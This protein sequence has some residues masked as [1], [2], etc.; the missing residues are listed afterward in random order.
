MHR[1]ELVVEVL[2]ESV[3]G[4]FLLTIQ[5]SEVEF[6]NGVAVIGGPILFDQ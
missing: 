1:H 3:D 4:P 2:S 5:R 6:V